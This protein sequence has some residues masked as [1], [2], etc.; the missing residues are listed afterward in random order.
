MVL[1]SAALTSLQLSAWRHLKQ[2]TD[3]VNDRG[4]VRGEIPVK[5]DTNMVN[6][7]GRG[8]IAAK[9]ERKALSGHA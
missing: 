6:D 8:E 9:S 7:R 3:M 5:Q 1:S 2:E 4:R